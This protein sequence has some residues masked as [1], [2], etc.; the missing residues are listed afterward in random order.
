MAQYLAYTTPA[1]GHLYPIVPT[2]LALRGRGHSVT[3]RTLASEVTAMRALGLNAEAV[4]PAVEQRQ[5][6]DWKAK[7]PIG[8]TRAALQ[9]F[10]DRAPHDGKDLR[11]A[12]ARWKPD[13][14][15]IDINAW[16]ALAVAEASGLPWA[17]WC[18]Y[19]LP[20]PSRDAP[21]FG[22]GLPPAGGP[23][24]R[25]RDAIIRPVVMGLYNSV[26]PDLNRARAQLG[27]PALRHVAEG[28]TRSPLMLYLT[29]EP[30]EYPRSDWH[31]SVR[32]VGPGIWDSSNT[33]PDW[34]EEADK[35]LVL[36]TCSTEFQNDGRL[37]ETALEALKDEP[38]QVVATSAGVDP[39]RFTAPANARV[40]R[41]LPHGA[42]LR[43]AACVVC[44]GGMGITQ[45]ALAAGVPLCVVPFGRDQVEVAR[46]VVVADA[47]STVPAS[48]LRPDRLREAVRLAIR[49]KP[50]AE[51]LAAAF[52]R[53]GGAEESSRLLEDLPQMP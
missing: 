31:P 28:F 34:L 5:H 1:R 40:V 7:T 16:G 26:L 4:D 6:D 17:T 9:A 38:V 12:L 20:V 53:A 48:K 11:D 18:P 33:R 51:S 29:A 23:L 8:S 14:L 19:F 24:A 10:L 44:H 37:I 52:R 21:P 35:P 49:K 22:L 25:M 30:F 15:L 46:H 43:K 50:G 42:V 47:G 13:A 39:E 27:A 32:L 2:L 3:V 36:V 41:F 45:K